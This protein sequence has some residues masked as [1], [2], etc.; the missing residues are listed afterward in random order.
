MRALNRATAALPGALAL[1]A[2]MAGCGSSTSSSDSSATTAPPTTA[3]PQVAV[4][5][6]NPADRSTVEYQKLTVRG[7]VTPATAAVKV[8]GQDAVVNDGVFQK[9]VGLNPGVNRLDIVATAPGATPATTEVTVTYTS[10]AQA[11]AKEKA[12]KEKAAAEAKAAKEARAK[13]AQKRKQESQATVPDLQGERLDVAEDELDGK[14]LRYTEIG[15]GAFGIVVRSNWTVCSTEPSGGAQ[16]SKGARVKLIVD[17][18][19]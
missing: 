9:A 15:G 8:R 10:A 3:P 1:L 2:A 6:S 18:S 19:C 11:A 5:V 4:Q 12:A 16:V 17:R 13:E 7:T 14:G